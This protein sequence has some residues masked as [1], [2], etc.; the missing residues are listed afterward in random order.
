MDLVQGVGVHGEVV[1]AAVGV[2]QRH[3]VGHEGGVGAAARFIAAE[4]VEVGGVD[5]RVCVMN[6]AS[7]WLEAWA[8][9]ARAAPADCQEGGA[10]GGGDS[11]KD[12]SILPIFVGVDRQVQ[13]T[14]GCLTYTNGYKKRIQLFVNVGD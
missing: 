1:G 8:D 14:A 13:E 12:I 4:H 9:G 2:L 3:V 11:D 5:L 6:G 7:R 10:Q